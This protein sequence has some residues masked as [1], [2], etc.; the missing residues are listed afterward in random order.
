MRLLV[1]FF[2]ALKKN[3][4]KQ[5]KKPTEVGAKA[6]VASAVS[7]NLSTAMVVMV[8]VHVLHCDSAP[9]ADHKCLNLALILPTCNAEEA[10][11]SPVLP[12]GVSSNLEIKHTKLHIKKFNESGFSQ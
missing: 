2:S 7:L 1:W 4:N 6:K 3:N 5:Q 12:P 10:I 9:R 11:F 8:I